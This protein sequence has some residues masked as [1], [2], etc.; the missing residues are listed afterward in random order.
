MT[1]AKLRSGFGASVIEVLS[2]LAFLAQSKQPKLKQPKF[3]ND[4]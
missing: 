3:K 2:A 1:G 4:E